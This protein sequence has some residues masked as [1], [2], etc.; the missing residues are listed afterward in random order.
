MELGLLGGSRRAELSADRAGLLA[1]QDP[2]VS[3]GM[4]LKMAGGRAG[5]DEISLDEFLMQ[6]EEYEIVV[7]S[8]DGIMT[9]LTLSFRPPPFNTA[10]AA[11][12]TRWTRRGASYRIIPGDFP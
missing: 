2:T 5:D 1:S 6:A 3:M 4:F 10:P 12:L 9:V 7:H 8:L 11:E